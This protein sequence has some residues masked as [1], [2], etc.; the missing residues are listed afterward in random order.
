MN[1]RKILLVIIPFILFAM[2]TILI[3]AGIT[4][5]FEGWAYKESIEHMVPGLTS[6]MKFITH[7]GDTITVTIFC[8]I[9]IILP[10]ARNTIAWPVSITVIASIILNLLFKNIFNRERPD[11]LRLINETSYSFPSGHAMINASLYTV[12]IL[13]IFQYVKSIPK[14]LTL[15]AICVILTAA[16]GFSRVYLGVHYAG[17]ILGGWF[18]GVAVAV[19]VYFIWNVKWLSRT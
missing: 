8:L 6:I 11:I 13:L 18:L 14:K 16:I 19:C 15:S 17:D 12:L 3:A 1:K 10:K 5:N 4:V 2:I 9:L 7:I